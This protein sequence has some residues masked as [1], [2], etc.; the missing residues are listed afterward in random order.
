MKHTPGPWEADS[1]GLIYPEQVSEAVARG[2][3]ADPHICRV[4][5][6]RDDEFETNTRIIAA[7]PMLLE[8]L[9]QATAALATIASHTRDANVPTGTALRIYALE[10][11]R[12]GRITLNILEEDPRSSPNTD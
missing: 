10:A 8:A 9:R 4:N 2:E 3:E 5:S 11:F 1:D 12:A 7:A 6:A